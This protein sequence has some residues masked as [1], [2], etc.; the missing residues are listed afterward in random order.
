MTRFIPMLSLLLLL[1]TTA[2]NNT[3]TTP[4]ENSNDDESAPAEIPSEETSFYQA[5]ESL[6]AWVDLL[7]VR[8]EP[9]TNAKVIATLRENETV[10]FT[11]ECTDELLK[12]DLRGQSFEEPWLKV[13]TSNGEE[14]WIF[15]GA[16]KR[17]GENK[18]VKRS[19]MSIG[20]LTQ[21]QLQQWTKGNEWKSGGGDAENVT[22]LYTKE[23]LTLAVQKTEV[24]EYGYSRY[25]ELFNKDYQLIKK[26]TVNW[27]S[28]PAFALKET[29]IDL[30]TE[31]AKTYT[32][33]QVFKS[34]FFQLNPRPETV[35]GDFKEGT[36]GAEEA[37][38]LRNTILFEV[39]TA[40]E[41][42]ADLDKE[43]GCSCL[44]ELEEYGSEFM[45][46]ASDYG[47]HGT[48]KVNGEMIPL[49]DG[50]PAQLA[51]LKKQGEQSSWITLREKGDTE[52]FGEKVDFNGEWRASIKSE[53]KQTMMAMDRIPTEARIDFVGTVGMGTRGDFRDLWREAVE[54]AQSAKKQ[55]N[56]LEL[57]Y[58][59]SQYNCKIEA[60]RVSQND[61]GG[62][63]YEGSLQVLS[64]EGKL[65]NSSYVYGECGC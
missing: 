52:L 57:F 17:Q 43:S 39:F 46:F 30:E 23:G 28:D 55:D 61:G 18:G 29:V 25:Y 32:R 24:G 34:H 45:V 33:S 3:S 42:P 2:C 63:K 38:A 65:L 59:G 64:K 14:G 58:Q 50:L 62:G 9:A 53:L 20:E 11:G 16:V 6:M 26:R 40:E 60:T 12:L 54:E 41:L 31:P 7:N 10:T 44:F 15:G 8:A 21:L 48:I 1:L 36:L 35:E 49:R 13:K 56:R 19:S 5:N 37:A 22:T 47:N 27:E 51:R 4:N